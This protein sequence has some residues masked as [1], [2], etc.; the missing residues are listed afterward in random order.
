MNA[1]QYLYETLSASPELVGVNI[2]A[3]ERPQRYNGDCITY[4]ETGINTIPSMCDGSVY[5]SFFQIDV[6]GGEGSFDNTELLAQKVIAALRENPIWTLQNKMDFRE[7]ESGHPRV[8]LE[9]KL[10]KTFKES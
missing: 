7:P 3:M 5:V 2:S 1:K 10:N 4:M 6:W 8:I 9:Y